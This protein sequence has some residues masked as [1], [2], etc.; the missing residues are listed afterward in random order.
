MSSSPQSS[1]AGESVY[2]PGEDS[3][4]EEAA[5]EV[6]TPEETVEDERIG[7]PGETSAPEDK[8]EVVT[9]T[10][11]TAQVASKAAEG[12]SAGQ[13]GTDQIEEDSNLDGGDIDRFVLCLPNSSR[14]H[15][16]QHE[17]EE[18]PQLPLSMIGVP[19]VGSCIWDTRVLFP[20][21]PSDLGFSTHMA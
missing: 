4:P 8:C 6:S 16:D 12:R 20:T 5:E 3:A 21:W 11:E 19:Q 7:P 9:G 15:T 17:E 10:L 14:V 13:G 2:P 18:V 1:N